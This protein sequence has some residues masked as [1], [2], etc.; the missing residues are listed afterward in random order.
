MSFD[1]WDQPWAI[2]YWYQFDLFGMR[3][4][5]PN[6]LGR[7]FNELPHLSCFFL[8]NLQHWSVQF[9]RLHR[10][11]IRTCRNFQLSALWSQLSNLLWCHY[12]HFVWVCSLRK[13]SLPLIRGMP[14]D[15]S[16]H[17]LPRLIIKNLSWLWRI[18]PYM[19]RSLSYR[20]S[21]LQQ[22]FLVLSK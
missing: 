21:I 14:D 12:L 3:F 20:M 22:W 19:F 17:F 7:D 18:M 5:L 1:N 16:W 8:S 9:H 4:Y 11:S 10:W 2:S 15:L 13:Q 6:L